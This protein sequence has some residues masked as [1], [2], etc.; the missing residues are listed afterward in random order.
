MR[1]PTSR[2]ITSENAPPESQ[3][4]V[5]SIAS[6]LNPFMENVVK[7]ING[8]L[9]L[10]NIAFKLVRVEVIVDSKGLLKTPP[11]VNTG[12]LRPING[13]I[14][15]N[16]INGLSS[17]IPPDIETTPTVLFNSIGN[18]NIKMTKV[19]NLKENT[20]YILILLVL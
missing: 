17:N 5:E 3:Q 8:N 10:D 20:K 16:V 19:L 1:L 4:M 11:D 2:R 13:L 7:A 9:D 15:V 12:L 14:C 18:G 6:V